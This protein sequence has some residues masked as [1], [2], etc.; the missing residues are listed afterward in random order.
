M[1]IGNLEYYQRTIFFSFKSLNSNKENQYLIFQ[2]Q[3]EG[4]RR[5][6]TEKYTS[7]KQYLVTKSSPTVA[8]GDLELRV[9]EGDILGVIQQKDPLGNRGRWFCDNGA[10]KGFVEADCLVQ[11]HPVED[12]DLMKPVAVVAP[13]DE[14]TEDEYKKPTR[15]APPVPRAGKSRCDQMSV[16]SYEEIGLEPSEAVL[17][18][19]SADLSPLYEEI[20]GG[21]RCSVSSSSGNIA[22]SIIWGSGRN[23]CYI[24][25]AGN[26]RA[27]RRRHRSRVWPTGSLQDHRPGLPSSAT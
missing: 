2:P 27:A 21:S 18:T 20:P 9:R 25:N 16:H 17:E 15:K 13:Y 4:E 7:S 6:V 23:N 10:A 24:A 26:R 5:L 19:M 3:S 1:N 12:P 8:L 14:V 22:R 11:H